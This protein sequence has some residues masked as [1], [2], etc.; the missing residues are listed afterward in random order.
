MLEREDV[1]DEGVDLRL[2]V[3]AR[4]QVEQLLTPAGQHAGEGHQPLLAPVMTEPLPPLRCLA[5]ALHG[6]ADLALV[7]HREGADD[8]VGR[9]GQGVERLLAAGAG[10]ILSHGHASILSNED[11]QAPSA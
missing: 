9:G 10:A 3:L 11:G 6:F 7:V 1:L 4:D 2:A 8:L 5:G